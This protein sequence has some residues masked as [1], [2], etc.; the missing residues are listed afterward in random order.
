M[1]GGGQMTTEIEK[2]NSYLDNLQ[3]EVDRRKR[4]TLHDRSKEKQTSYIEQLRRYINNT[5]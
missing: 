3:S 5:K 2:L 4:R 1:K